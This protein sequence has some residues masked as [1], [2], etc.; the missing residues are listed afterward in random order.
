[1]ED[2]QVVFYESRKLN[3]HE[4]NYLTH[5]LELAVIIQELEM[6]RHYIIAKKFVLMSDHIRLRHL[7]DQLNLNTKQAKWLATIS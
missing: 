7:F 1:M 6:W 5:H 2:G 4:Q 3:D